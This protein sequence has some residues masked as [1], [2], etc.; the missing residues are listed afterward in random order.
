MGQSERLLANVGTLLPR[1]T[2]LHSKHSNLIGLRNLNKFEVGVCDNAKK[3]YSLLLFLSHST[4]HGAPDERC[5]WAAMAPTSLGE[6]KK[7]VCMI[8]TGLQKH[9]PLHLVCFNSKSR[10]VRTS[11]MMHFR[12]GS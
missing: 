4:A 3:G 6:G 1:S 7:P 8:L 10:K 5:L 11:V 12:V 9:V 2:S